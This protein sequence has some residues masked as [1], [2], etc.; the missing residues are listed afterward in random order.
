MS[1]WKFQRVVVGG[2]DF[3]VDLTEDRSPV[4]DPAVTPGPRTQT[5]DFLDEDS[6][7][8]GNRQTATLASS[9]ARK[10]RVPE[11]K[12]CV[13]SLSPTLAGRVLTLCRL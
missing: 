9:G 2:L 3:F 13:V 1:I 5:P 11:L 6:S 7:V 12:R 10:P 8:P 4:F